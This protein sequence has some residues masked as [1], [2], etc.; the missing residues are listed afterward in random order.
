MASIK[1]KNAM[2]HRFTSGALMM[3]AFIVSSVIGLVFHLPFDNRSG[4]L[5]IIICAVIFLGAAWLVCASFP[6]VIIKERTLMIVNFLLFFIALMVGFY[7][8][9]AGLWIAVITVELVIVCSAPIFD[10][11]DIKKKR[12]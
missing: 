4:L 6:N 7:S 8:G 11:Y 10:Y 3:L 2:S 5:R 1:L 12:S 9:E